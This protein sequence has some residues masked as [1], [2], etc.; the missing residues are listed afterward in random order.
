M[1]RL[2]PERQQ[3]VVS[4]LVEGNSVR[5]TERMTGVHRDTIARLVLRLGVG[6]QRIL[7][8]RLVDLACD[9]VQLD[10]LWCFVGK[11][12]RHVTADDDRSEV[13]DTWTWVAIDRD[14][15]LVPSHLVG[16]RTQEFAVK[17]CRD[18]AGRMRNRVQVSSD[19]L[20]AY[21]F[22]VHHAFG[23]EVDYGTVVKSYEAEPI[24]PG[25][26]S[27][28][29]VVEIRK[30]AEYGR[31]DV[32]GLCTSHVERQNLT[33]R[34]SMRRFTRLTNGFS[35]KLENLKAAVSLH[36]AHYNFVR[37]HRTIRTTPAV[38][39]GVEPAPWSLADLVE[40]SGNQ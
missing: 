11:K 40:L 4:A 31:P 2:K 8:E 1:N 20:S 36:F 13:G 30:Q 35:K 9:D 34:M 7:D 22:A 5:S 12:Q 17:F 33:M 16:K 26:Y 19:R 24:G 18:L 28:P 25:R 14:T 21:K 6:C 37:R 10:E 29:K 27:P 38:A 32:Q 23:G 39:A 15:K 3:S